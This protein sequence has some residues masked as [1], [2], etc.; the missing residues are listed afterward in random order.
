M[1][2]EKYV[3]KDEA[4]KVL[5]PIAELI[6]EKILFPAMDKV[7]ADSDNSFDDAALAIVKPMIMAALNKIDGEE[8]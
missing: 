7:V 4:M 1:G 6:V 5:E 2:I 3:D 8:G